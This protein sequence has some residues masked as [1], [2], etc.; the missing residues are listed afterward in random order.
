VQIVNIS[1]PN[2]V[3]A[4]QAVAAAEAARHIL[5]EKPM[6]CARPACGALSVSCCVGTRCSRA[7]VPCWPTT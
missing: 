2:Q 1:G 6:P 3:H 7:F 4:D 5:V